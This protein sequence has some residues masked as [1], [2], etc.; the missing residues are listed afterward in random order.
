M[1]IKVGVNQYVSLLSLVAALAIKRLQIDIEP[2]QLI[3][4][5]TLTAKGAGAAKASRKFSVDTNN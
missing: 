1:S 2:Y 5:S 3:H 4:L